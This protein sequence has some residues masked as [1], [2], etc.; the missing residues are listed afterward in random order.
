MAKERIITAHFNSKN[1]WFEN[2]L[3][4]E[5]NYTAATGPYEY[6]LGALAG[7]Y[8][9]TLCSYERKGSWEDIELKI[10]GLKRDEVPST[11]KTTILQMKVKGASDEEEFKALAEKAQAECSIYRTI[12][13]V[14]DMVVEI[15]FVS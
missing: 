7:C 15:K 5:Y 12:S 3:G 13:S 10:T 9:S 6:L 4:T 1:R 2:Q 14:S 8:L 11:L